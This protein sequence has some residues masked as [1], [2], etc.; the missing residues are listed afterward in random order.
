MH[1]LASLLRDILPLLVASALVVAF[2][3]LVT[4][5]TEH[6]KTPRVAR[7]VNEWGITIASLIA[8]VSAFLALWYASSSTASTLIW[9][10]YGLLMLAFIIL[11]MAF[12]TPFIINM[13]PCLWTRVYYTQFEVAQSEDL[14][15]AKKAIARL[16]GAGKR[17]TE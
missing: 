3:P 12:L 1:P 9:V 5:Q 8:F 6:E 15:E 16:K 17:K 13:I 7:K 10:S 11:F 2:V 14:K 4:R